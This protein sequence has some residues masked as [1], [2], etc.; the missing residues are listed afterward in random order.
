M[1]RRTP[2]FFR[3]TLAMLC[4]AGTPQ[5]TVESAS[6]R[7][8]ASTGIVNVVKEDIFGKTSNGKM[9]RR[10]TLKNRQGSIL[11]VIEL[12]ATATELHVADREGNF[13]DVVLG[14][15]TVA[16]YERMSPILDVPQGVL[17]TALPAGASNSMGQNTNSPSISGNTIYTAA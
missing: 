17:P 1:T 8:L 16:E 3:A 2:H 7:Q 11:K 4:V 12:G 5:S 15:E 10:Y 13:T 6:A 14:F 9:V